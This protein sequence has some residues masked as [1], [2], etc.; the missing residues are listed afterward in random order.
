MDILCKVITNILHIAEILIICRTYLCLP[1]RAEN[2]YG[3]YKIF[4]IIT[5]ASMINNAIESYTTI[6][7]LIYLLCI[8]IVVIIYFLDDWKKLTICAFWVSVI[9]ELID[10]ISLSIMNVFES[11]FNIHS[12]LIEELF[13]TIL[14]VSVIYV[15]GEVLQKM[16]NKDGIRKIG[17]KD[18]IFFTIILMVDMMVSFLMVNVTLEQQSSKHQIFYTVIYTAVVIGIFIQLAAVILLLVSRNSYQEK[19]QIIA[20]YLEEQ[21]KYYEYLRDQEQETKKFRH[22]IRGHL[23]FLNKLKNEGKNREFEEYFQELI[24][25]V[26]DL[27]N[28]VHVGNDIVN[29]VLSKADS[30]ARE[31]QIKMEITG[32]LPARCNISVYHL[33]TIFSNLLNNAIEAA[34]KTNKRKIWVICRYTQEEI[35]VEI[36]N[37]FSCSNRIEKGSLQTSK[38]DQNYHGWGMKNVMDSVKKCRGL[39]DIEVIEDQFIVSVTLNNENEGIQNEDSNNR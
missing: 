9:V 32:H 18:L 36:G 14:S 1:K 15:V 21:V 31:K 11:L 30:E 5:L 37:Y 19:E 7:L 6:A 16:S 4:M 13:A 28:H 39:I 20:Q 29:A 2:K 34:E 27:G 25:R 17:V 8:E 33:C 35:I 24:G 10:L 22:D 23:Y 12:I 38:N 3:Y 26:D